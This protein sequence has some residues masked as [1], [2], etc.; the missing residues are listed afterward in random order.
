MEQRGVPVVEVLQASVNSWK[1]VR[2]MVVC[3]GIAKSAHGRVK[4]VVRVSRFSLSRE[5]I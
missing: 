3:S 4:S 2:R 5:R 1:L